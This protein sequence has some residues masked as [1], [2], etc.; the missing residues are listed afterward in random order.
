LFGALV[1]GSVHPEVLNVA[2]LELFTSGP[3]VRSIHPEVLNVTQ[4]ELFISGIVIRSI[5]PKVV[6]V[7]RLELVFRRLD[8]G[9]VG[10][11]TA[12]KTK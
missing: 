6:N 2:R 7:A 9:V 1:V 10:I 8:L 11:A 5:Y 12:P 3:G 4:L